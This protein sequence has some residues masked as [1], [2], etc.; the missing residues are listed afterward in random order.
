LFL[1]VPV[2]D[3]M[4]GA[5]PILTALVKACLRESLSVAFEGGED[6]G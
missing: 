4:S 5:T 1:K 2:T 6:E 3:A